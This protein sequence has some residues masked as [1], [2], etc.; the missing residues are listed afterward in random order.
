MGLFDIFKKGSKAKE[1]KVH[2]LPS[3]ILLDEAELDIDLFV[4]NFYED[5]GVQIPPDD[6]DSE[7]EDDDLPMIVATID[8]MMV[9]VSLIPAPV[10]NGEAV[11]NAKTNFR[12]PDAVAVTESHKAHILVAILPGGEPSLKKIATLHTKLCATCLRQPHAVA[13]NTA[14]TVFAPDFY[15]ETAKSL[16]EKD[17]FPIMNHVF[18]GIYSNDN[19]KTFSGYTYGLG[20]LGKQD[21]EILNSTH[22]ANEIFEFMADI[23]LYVMESNAVL[24]HGETLGST[25]EEKLK[26]TESAGVALDGKTLKIEY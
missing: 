2:V 17:S 21:I 9:A 11:E 14:G 10:P 23:A 16:I 20:D 12:W 7:K 1:E 22:D 25:A 5:W 15:I 6:D 4:K 3:F 13:I 26:I 24:R 18:F 8:N 19:G